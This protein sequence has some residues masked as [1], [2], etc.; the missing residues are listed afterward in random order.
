MKKLLTL[1]LFL[2]LPVNT[3][4]AKTKWSEMSLRDVV[5]EARV[6][7]RNIL[8]EFY[9]DWYPDCSKIDKEVFSSKDGK[10]LSDEMYCL[11][12][13]AEKGAG[14]ELSKK[15]NIISYP[16]V[17]ILDKNG[18]ETDRIL[19]YEN[20]SE[21]IDKVFDYSKGKGILT[22]LDARIRKNPKDIS[23]LFEAGQRYAFKGNEKMASQYLN[24]VVEL[25]PKNK[26]GY[27]DKALYALGKYLYSRSLKN[28]GKALPLLAELENN[29]PESSYSRRTDLERAKIYLEMKKEK[30]VLNAL[31]NYILKNK[32]DL[33]GKPQ[34]AFGWFCYRNQFKIEQGL[35]TAKEGSRI[36]PKSHS[37]FNTLA[38]LYSALGQNE[39]ALNA[40][41]K[42][43]Q[44][45]SKSAHYKKQLKKFKNK[46]ESV[47]KG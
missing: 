20:K 14:I 5:T 29:F 30:Q 19:D 42:A 21:F 7:E 33:S 41:R 3:L 28:Y 4:C 16:T 34:N 47:E 1:V 26:K 27:S 10:K 44:L 31:N 46:L 32:S 11:K 38:E 2:V 22:E 43:L 18:D 12:Y 17:I 24:K 13:N 39:K 8:L 6:L 9:A 23:T 15:Y 25:D 36:N 37:I 40:A 35:K 45:N